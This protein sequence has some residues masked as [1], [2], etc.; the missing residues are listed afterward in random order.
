MDICLYFYYKHQN[1]QKIESFEKIEHFGKMEHFSKDTFALTP[2]DICVIIFEIIALIIGA[3]MLTKCRKS[4][5]WNVILYIFSPW[6]YVIY[7]C[8]MNSCNTQLNRKCFN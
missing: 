5:G 2:Q 3:L 1:S 6:L 8:Y 7:N 4:I